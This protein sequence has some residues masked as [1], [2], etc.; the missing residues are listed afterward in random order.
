MI[1]KQHLVNNGQRSIDIIITSIDTTTLHTIGRFNV[2]E[3]YVAAVPVIN[4]N[5]NIAYLIPTTTREGMCSTML[6]DFLVTT[7]NEFIYYYHKHYPLAEKYSE[8]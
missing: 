3:E 7:H 1:A 4:N 2:P 8:Q 5:T 6:L